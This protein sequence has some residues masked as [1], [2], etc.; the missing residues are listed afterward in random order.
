[1]SDSREIDKLEKRLVGRLIRSGDAGYDEA[2]ALWNGMIDRHPRMIVKCKAV[3]DVMAAVDFAR[4]NDLPVAVRG[5][6]HNVAGHGTCDAGI[7]IDMSPMRRV[8]VDPEK[9]NRTL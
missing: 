3:T 7:V 8:E 2:R 6:G 1:M 9:R 5:G 4:E